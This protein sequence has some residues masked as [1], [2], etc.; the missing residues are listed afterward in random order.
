MN[1][2]VYRYQTFTNGIAT[3]HC[4]YV[5]DYAFNR[6]FI[7]ILQSEG[8]CTRYAPGTANNTTRVKP[9]NVLIIPSSHW[10]KRDPQALSYIPYHKRIGDLLSLIATIPWTVDLS[11]VSID[12][13]PEFFI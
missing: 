6:T 13:Y 11:T 12:D 9:C 2:Y 7:E 5:Y 4:R 1:Y 10:P 3:T 8:S